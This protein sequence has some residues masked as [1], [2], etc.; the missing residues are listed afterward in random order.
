[1][2]EAERARL[3]ETHLDVARSAAA[4]V[5]RRAK[6]QI[7]LDDL[8]GFANEGLA[9]AAL[10]YDPSKGASFR[11]WAWYRV[12][13]A[14]MDNMRRHSN[15]PRRVWRKLVALRAAGEYLENL[16]ERDAGAA[17][18][19]VQPKQGKDALAQIKDSLSAIRT[20]YVMS[21]DV[22]VDERNFD[23]ADDNPA[24]G[25][26]LDTTRLARKLRKA[27]EALPE[28]ERALV[29]KHY[30]EGK[31]LLEAGAELGI[32]KSWASRLHAQAVEKLRAVI[33]EQR[34]SP[35]TV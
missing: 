17:K 8:I 25:D 9:E 18:R 16:G 30:Y 20:M 33:D 23:K 5:H 29:T 35:P 19:G 14:L 32:S 34:G 11:T 21:L 4:L 10:S 31:N 28:K 22:L 7:E 13:G 27:L 1:V 26:Q 24:L 12:N 6:G 15:L 3:V 2:D